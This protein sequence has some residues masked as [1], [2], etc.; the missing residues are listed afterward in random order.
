MQS[1]DRLRIFLIC[2]TLGLGTF[3]AFEQVRQNDFINFDDTAYVTKNENVQ[4]GLTID[5]FVWAFTTGH[6]AN[7][8]PLTWLSHMFDY[9]LYGLNPAGHHLTN[10]LLHILSTLLLFAVL[11]SMTGA[12]WPSAFVAAMFALHPLHVE[13]VAWIAERKDVLSGF[14]WMLT[15]AA[16]VRYVKHPSLLRYLGVFLS[17]CLG[18][19]AKP[20]LVSLPFVLLLLDYWPLGRF[21]LQRQAASTGSS[22]WRLFVEKIPLIVLVIISS[23][24]TYLVQQ[25]GGAMWDVEA[26]PMG[27]RLANVPVSY[28]G[29]LGKMIYPV[30]LAVLYPHPGHSLVMRQAVTSL[31]V[32]IFITAVVIYLSRRSAYLLV[33][34]LWYLGTLVPVIG[35]VQVGS[36]AMADRY[37]YLPLTGIFIMAAWTV[38]RLSAKWRYR[39]IVLGI[40]AGLILIVLL[41][42]TRIQVDRWRNSE[43]LFERTLALTENNSI[44]NNNLGMFWFEKNDSLRAV[45]YFNQAIEIKPDFAEGYY[46]LARA[47]QSQENYDEAIKYYQQAIHIKSDYAAAHNNLGTALQLQHRL[48]EAISQ[49]RRALELKKDYVGAHY[50]LGMA[51]QITGELDEAIEQYRQTLHL[52]PKHASALNNLGRTFQSKQMFDEAV[53][54]YLEA[55]HIDPDLAEAN[56]NLGK[57]LRLNGRLDEAVIYFNQSLRSRPD[58]PDAHFSLALVWNLLNKYDKAII[59]FNE[60]LRLKP[61]WPQPHNNL[62]NIYYYQDRFDLAVVHWKQTVN[63]K[64]D[65]TEAL[66]NLAWILAAS[67]DPNLYNPPEALKF[68]EKA[69]ELTNYQQPRMLDT[70]AVAYAAAG[71]FTKAIETAEKAVQ[72]ADDDNKNLTA[73]IQKRIKLYKNN[74]PY[75]EPTPPQDKPRR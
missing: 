1:P 34:W 18:L 39:K 58:Y 31:L 14:F 17:L 41:V 59:H 63:L 10:L 45:N 48:D 49:Y 70:L 52:R 67:L 44:I 4:K 33:G 51:L 50:N 22:A 30:R 74:Q 23:V 57:I 29:Y 5:S 61:N 53:K 24:V 40:S 69:C 32:L 21:E 65:S 47:L 20:M 37:T 2:L 27:I 42:C 55:L 71:E 38:A 8:H 56:Y 16:Y 75:R 9:E 6:Q 66:N 26:F 64:P 35:L 60:A 25:R 28:I 11:N 13:S 54:C 15:I 62:G 73:Q 36:Q 3:I 72:L 7:W 43:T 68:A 46:N 19:M 12:I